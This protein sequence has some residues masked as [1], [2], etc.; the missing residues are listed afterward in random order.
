MLLIYL[1]EGF[2]ISQISKSGQ[3]EI[4]ELLFWTGFLKIL[5]KTLSQLMSEMSSVLDPPLKPFFTG[6]HFYEEC[7]I[8]TFGVIPKYFLNKSSPRTWMKFWLFWYSVMCMPFVMY[9][10]NDGMLLRIAWCVSKTSSEVNVIIL[11]WKHRRVRLRIRCGKPTNLI[12]EIVD[13]VIL[14][15]WL[16]NLSFIWLWMFL[17]RHMIRQ[18]MYNTFIALHLY[19]GPGHPVGRNYLPVIVTI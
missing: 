14:N 6:K 9:A 7:P 18:S 4:L 2:W 12:L 10:S 16:F 8:M 15:Y 11:E 5:A 13:K 19:W 1:V 3:A 17:I